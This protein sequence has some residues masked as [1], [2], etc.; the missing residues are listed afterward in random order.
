MSTRPGALVDSW[1]DALGKGNRAERYCCDGLCNEYQG[2][3][4]CPAVRARLPLPDRL[5]FTTPARL[6][7]TPE[8]V[9]ICV[10]VACLAFGAFVFLKALAGSL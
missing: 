7:P 8:R 5:L 6:W 2:R 1:R 4:G 3:G 9:A 10:V